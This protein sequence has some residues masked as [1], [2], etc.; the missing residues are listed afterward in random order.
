MNWAE[1]LRMAD[2][3]YTLAND[4][5]YDQLVALLNS[6]EINMGQHTPVYVIAYD[7]RLEKVRAEVTARN[8]VNLLDDPEILKRWEDFS[9]QIWQ[10]HPTALKN[11]Q[12]KGIN[13]VN[14]LGMHRRFCGFDPASPF[15]KFI[16]LD[17]DILV[18]NS[19]DP[20][21]EKLDTFDFAVY[22]FQY[23]DLAHVYNPKSER[24]SQVF[25]VSRLASE[26]FCAGMYGSKRGLF[27]QEQRD[28]LVAH[29]KAGD[30]E[31]LYPNAPDQSILNY[32]AMKSGLSIYNFALQLP[33]DQRTG[34]SV[35]SPHFEMK[36]QVLYDKGNRLTYLHYIGLSSKLFKELCEGKNID[37]PYR[38]IFLHYRYLHEPEKRPK[39][40]G[41]A[42]LYNAPPNL[43]RRALRK[44]GV[45]N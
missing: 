23:K 9:L 38:D 19:L 17:A 21:F 33:G 8:N 43:M 14:R 22:D 30:S 42:Q 39:F 24:L 36:N 45:R 10:T 26:I 12:E 34:N 13:G 41:K 15:E 18:L 40:T 27:N 25:E 44:I 7:D 11:W 3:I 1:E 29:L 6:I 20:I 16:Y 35:T 2:G 32:M 37:F 31:I 28:G 5:V 4:V